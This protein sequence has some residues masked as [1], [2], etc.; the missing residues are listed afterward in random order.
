MQMMSHPGTIPSKR[1]QLTEYKNWNEVVNWGLS[2]NGYPNLKSPL[3]D[4][5]IK[6]F[7]EQ[8]GNDQ[9]KYIELATRFVQDE[10]RY[11]GIEMGIYSHRP[12]SPERV[13]KQRYGDCKDKSLLLVHL[14]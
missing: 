1:A 14:L 13:L 5:K 12:N 10:I 8:A 11:M 9:K 2:I 6:E 4:K 7:K 3:L